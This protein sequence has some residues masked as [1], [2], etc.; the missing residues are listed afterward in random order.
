MK[1]EPPSKTGRWHAAWQTIVGSLLVIMLPALTVLGAIL[2]S[3]Q[4]EVYGQPVALQPEGRQEEFS[5][6]TAAVT[7]PAV[8][9][10]PTTSISNTVEPAA[11]VSPTLRANVQPEIPSPTPEIAATMPLLGTAAPAPSFTPWPCA[12]Y[13]PMDWNLY[14]VVRGDTLFSLAR[15][16]STSMDEAILYNC[17]TSD[18]LWAG[19]RLY[20]PVFPT[21][22]LS[23]TATLTPTPSPTATLT[24][25]S[26]P[27][28][29]PTPSS[30]STPV[31]SP[32][33]SPTVL[34]TFTATPSPIPF[35][36]ET[37]N[38]TADPSPSPTATFTPSVTAP[39]SPTA[40]TTI[41]ATVPVQPTTSPTLTSTPTATP[42]LS[43]TATADPA[44]SPSPSLTPT[45]T[46]TP[47]PAP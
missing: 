7:S 33:P 31:S 22:Q 45:E 30:T 43:P 40:T 35:A 3:L 26:S 16:H 38:P 42:D 2:L 37:A 41:T 5:P 18:Q 34:P 19:Q 1:P 21:S 4:G 24:P 28:S 44:V 23:A 8:T 12:G 15:R 14:I 46:L 36:T 27:T 10:H 20:L 25:T 11:M 13:A 39:A 9:L 17:L 47:S 29:T 32:S 6:T